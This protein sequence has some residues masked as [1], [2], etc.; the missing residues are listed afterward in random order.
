LY[1]RSYAEIPPRVEYRLT[2][3]GESFSGLME[4]IERLQEELDRSRG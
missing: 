2:P 4:A 3:Y 1:K